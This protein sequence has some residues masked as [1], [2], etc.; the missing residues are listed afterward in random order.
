MPLDAR[1]HHNP[2]PLY[3][4]SLLRRTGLSQREA[5]EIIGIPLRTLELYLRV[6]GKIRADYRTQVALELLSESAQRVIERRSG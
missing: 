3:L 5:A 1:K 2:D 6:G 4:R